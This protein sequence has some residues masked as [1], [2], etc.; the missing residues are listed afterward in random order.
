MILVAICSGNL[1]KL[2]NILDRIL[3]LLNS[4]YFSSSAGPSIG[5]ELYQI[6]GIGS[7]IV[8]TVLCGLEHIP[9]Y[10]LRPII[11]VFLRPFIYSCPPIFHN[12][13]LLPIMAHITPFSKYLVFASYI[14]S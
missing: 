12:D 4:A 7:A 9:D 3:F 1:F 2:C 11:R 5:R 13:V 8:Q 6:P 14:K 10:R